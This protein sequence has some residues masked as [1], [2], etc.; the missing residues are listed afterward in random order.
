[1]KQRSLKLTVLCLFALVASAAADTS[2]GH[3]TYRGENFQPELKQVDGRTFYSLDDP[4]IKRLLGYST[5]QLQW[6]S[7]GQTL[8]VFTPGRESFWSNNSDRVSVNKQ[9]MTAPGRL[10]ASNQARLMEPQALLYAL[11]LRP[12]ANGQGMTLLPAVTEMK[13]VVSD[14]ATSHIVL[15]TSSPV[16]PTV[17]K[18]M[19]NVCQLALG[20]VVWDLPE[21]KFWCGPA[22]AEI[23]GGTGLDDPLTIELTYRHNW[24]GRLDNSSLLNDVKVAL[25]PDFPVPSNAPNSQL[26]QITVRPQANGNVALVALDTPMQYF[27]DYDKRS[28]WVTIEIPHVEA[29]NLPQVKGLLEEARLSLIETSAYPVLR[30]EGRLPQGQG[31]EFFEV[32]DSPSTLGLRVGAGIQVAEARGAATTAGYAVARG[33]IV[34]DPGHGGSDPGC[35]NRTLGVRECDV[36]LQISLKLADILRAQGWEVVLTRTTDR[37]V[38]YAGSPD[39]D[40]LVARSDVA[41]RINADIFVSIHCNAAYSSAHNGTSIH[42]YKAED[43]QLAQSLEN[44]LGYNVGFGQKGLIRNRFVVLRYAQM[45][46]VLVETAY[47]TNNREGAMLSNPAFQKVIA[48]QLAGGLASYMQGVYASTKQRRSQ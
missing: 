34:I 37:D 9:D 17:S 21:R 19:P 1:M 30:L 31:F 10:L 45:P 38:T 40:E 36:T 29:A 24:T 42:W 18:P 39:K 44:V 8:Y 27:W 5:S 16:K 7:S 22:W 4:E 26:G 15:H 43:Y 35:M 14:E 32:E 6:S 13:A 28:G 2:F 12:F 47:L 48:Q 23:K 3:L 20:D 33:T 41:N 46:S 11:S 25:Q